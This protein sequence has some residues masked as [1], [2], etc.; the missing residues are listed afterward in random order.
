MPVITANKIVLLARDHRTQNI[1]QYRLV[2]NTS[3]LS[4]RETA[5]Y[6]L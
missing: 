4:F 5:L 3:I 1:E 6:K 2:G